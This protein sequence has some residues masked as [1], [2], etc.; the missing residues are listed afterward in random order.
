MADFAQDKKRTL[1]K[2]YKPDK[3]KKGTVDEKIISLINL[4]NSFDAYYTTSSCSG[5]ITLFTDNN[6][7]VKSDAKWLYVTHNQVDSAHILQ[8]VSSNLPESVLWFRQEGFILHVCAKD[9]RSANYLLQFAQNHGFKKTTLL[10][11]SK[12]FI[13]EIL[14]TQRLDAPIAFQEKLLVT[15]EYIKFLVLLANKKLALTHAQIEK[16]ELALQQEFLK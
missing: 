11:A 7:K 10:T 16:F 5:R 12:R 14:S 6:S 9:L 1:E 15:N 2:L 4:I 8:Q 13:V 3:S